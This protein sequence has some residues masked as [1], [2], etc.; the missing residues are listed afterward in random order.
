MQ[1]SLRLSDYSSEVWIYYCLT[2]PRLNQNM[3]RDNH[4]VTLVRIILAIL[5]Q[6]S[7]KQW[8]VLMF[9]VKFCQW[10]F[11]C[12]IR[13]AFWTAP[14]MKVWIPLGPPKGKFFQTTLPAFHC[15]YQ[16]SYLGLLVFAYLGLCWSRALDRFQWFQQMSVFPDALKKSNVKCKIANAKICTLWCLNS[17]KK[18]VNLNY[19][20]KNFINYKFFE[21]GFLTLEFS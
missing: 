19:V 2:C 7:E 8:K 16:A 13:L 18:L 15:L 14:F 9:S 12:G 5:I 1:P 3:F 20:S 11:S 10:Q 21:I 6:N 17:R 4:L